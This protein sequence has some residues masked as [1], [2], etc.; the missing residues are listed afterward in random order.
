MNVW[1]I[2]QIEPTPNQRE[3]KKAYAKQLKQIDPDDT[4][5]FIRLREAFETAQILANHLEDEVENRFEPEF[6]NDL[7]HDAENRTEN[8]EI[9]IQN[10]PEFNQNN[11]AESTEQNIEQNTEKSIE[12]NPILTH[13]K[14]LNQDDN[15]KEQAID[16]DD[17]WSK[18]HFL[19]EKENQFILTKSTEQDGFYAD[20]SRLLDALNDGKYD[21]VTFEL[22]QKVLIAMQDLNLNE[23]LN[24]KPQILWALSNHNYQEQFKIEILEFLLLWQY[25]Y[26]IEQNFDISYE[27]EQILEMTE[28]YQRQT[29]LNL[30]ESLNSAKVALLNNEKFDLFGM[31]KLNGYLHAH[32]YE[33]EIE[34]DELW[35][36]DKDENINFQYLKA[37]NSIPEKYLWVIV[38]YG[39]LLFL[40]FI[41]MVGQDINKVILA[42]VG[43]LVSL[44]L[45]IFA[46]APLLAKVYTQHY[47]KVVYINAVWF[48]SAFVLCLFT[49]FASSI[50]YQIILI[51]WTLLSY[52]IILFAVQRVGYFVLSIFTA[53]ERLV[54][55][56]YLIGFLL[57]L[58]P[59][60]A[61]AELDQHYLMPLAM[62]PLIFIAFNWHF[63]TVLI[64]AFKPSQRISFAD[65][66]TT[67]QK[68]VYAVAVLVLIRVFSL[69]FSW[70]DY[71]Y[72]YLFLL[73]SLFIL[74]D[75]K[76]ISY[77]L[78]YTALLLFTVVLGVIFMP[79]AIAGFIL[80]VRNV[81]LDYQYYRHSSL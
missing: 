48:Y 37:L 6:E 30:P 66:L 79:F 41:H 38:I 76:M 11:Q 27:E 59:I 23:Q 63:E 28:F 65:I 9:D 33:N 14:D 18:I 12:N 19:N 81:W 20:Y 58:I 71:P 5:A 74:L 4:Q 72:F 1:H 45:F 8:Q 42:V 62:I 29:M 55:D 78:K 25:Y 43:V 68:L 13:E 69:E 22:F 46:Y 67:P 77:L 32:R 21:A 31:L 47:H 61:M 10:K 35:V 73:S 44:A 53:S 2:L 75:Y 7:T 70:Q 56:R 3:I 26:P 64:Q 17:V 34:L 51:L 54:I 57:V 16:L 40:P 39:V 24:L 15:R 36:K 60:V 80:L 49:P 50:Y 52:F